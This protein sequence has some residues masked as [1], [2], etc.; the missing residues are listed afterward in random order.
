MKLYTPL[1]SSRQS[2]LYNSPMSFKCSEKT[3]YST[4]S[5]EWVL[6]EGQSLFCVLKG[7]LHDISMRHGA[8]DEHQR[9][10]L[11]DHAEKV[12]TGSAHI[13]GIQ[14]WG[15]DSTSLWTSTRVP[16]VEVQNFLH[17]TGR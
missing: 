3:H 14:T 8:K 9:I 16:L 11:L 12:I 17:P 1:P 6:R 15:S 4:G 5:T 7:L 13:D 10:I 2:L